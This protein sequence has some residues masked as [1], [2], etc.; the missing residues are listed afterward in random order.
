MQ[1]NT[2]TAREKAVADVRNAVSLAVMLETAG[3]VVPKDFFMNS[4]ATQFEVGCSGAEKEGVKY[5]KGAQERRPL[6]VSKQPEDNGI[7]KH[8]I[9]YFLLMTS[10]SVQLSKCL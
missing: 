3:A 6:K 5:M 8:Y 1:K 9:K 4:D 2:T 7:T 10:S